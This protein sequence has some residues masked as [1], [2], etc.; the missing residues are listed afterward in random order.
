[1]RRTRLYIFVLVALLSTAQAQDNR[2]YF[3]V[4]GAYFS[5]ATT[6][7]FSLQVGSA[8]SNLFELRATLDTL[9][10]VNVVST[11]L[12]F[13]VYK[14]SVLKA[15]TGFGPDLLVS[16]VAPTASTSFEIHGTVGVEFRPNGKLDTGLY[17]E[18]KPFLVSTFKSG[19]L[20]LEFRA[21][22]NS[23]F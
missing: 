17:I 19:I 7:V 12:L 6:P 16:L 15:Y 3:G 21:G 20:A 9:L 2:S 14:N 5:G 1:M 10:S 11:D 8:I 4:G 18:T 22:I 23:H 13:A